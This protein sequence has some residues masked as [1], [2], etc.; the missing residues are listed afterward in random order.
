MRNAC[1]RF[2]AWLWC[3]A[4]KCLRPDGCFQRRATGLL[5]L[6]L[7]K[8]ELS[9]K[10][11]S[12]L[13]WSKGLRNDHAL[14]T[15]DMVQDEVLMLSNEHAQLL[16]GTLHDPYEVNRVASFNLLHHFNWYAC[17]LP[18]SGT[19]TLAPAAVALL[20]WGFA[21]IFSSHQNTSE[22]SSVVLA[23]L[24]NRFDTTS[25][26][27][28]TLEK[29]DKALQI[30]KDRHDTEARSQ[31]SKRF[32][33]FE[34]LWQDSRPSQQ[35]QDQLQHSIQLAFPVAAAAPSHLRIVTTLLAQLSEAV[36]LSYFQLLDTLSH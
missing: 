30:L 17:E 36:G 5:I 25:E 1:R 13:A 2:V 3:F 19:Q 24:H 22:S 16:L 14:Q 33:D 18:L 20:N 31:H 29:T 26:H 6:D 28:V 4:F 15:F 35:A 9:S 23:C 11:S 34:Q 21:N 7:I 10:L 32:Q 8:C 12:I 27:L